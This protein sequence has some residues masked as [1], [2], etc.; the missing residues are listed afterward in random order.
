[1]RE[2]TYGGEKR[3]IEPDQWRELM[4]VR[5]IGTWRPDGHHLI[6]IDDPV[7]IN[8]TRYE[9]GVYALG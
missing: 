8:G 5:G 4:K 6:R 9:P 3:V 1:M 2:W 7:E